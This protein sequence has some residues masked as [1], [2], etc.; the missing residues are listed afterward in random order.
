MRKPLVPAIAVV[1]SL[2]SGGATACVLGAVYNLPIPFGMYA[3]GATAAL[4][5]SF[6]IVAYVLK[7]EP[8]RSALPGSPARD[9]EPLEVRLSGSLVGAAAWVSVG[10]LLL[11]VSTGVYGTQNIMANLGMT[12]FWIVF[13]LGMTYATALVGDLYSLINPWRKLCNWIER[14]DSV[15]FRGRIPYPERLAYYPALVL[16]MS[17]IWIELFGEIQ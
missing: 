14:F 11:T 17:F 10:C 2:L 16:Y 6:V 3:S 4:F 1:L 8:A 9:G 13:S 15:A 5:A 7:A 12:M